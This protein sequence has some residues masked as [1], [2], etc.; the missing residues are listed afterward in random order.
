MPAPTV[1]ED[2]E[3]SECAALLPPEMLEQL[4]RAIGE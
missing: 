1:A 2:T 3:W 4:R